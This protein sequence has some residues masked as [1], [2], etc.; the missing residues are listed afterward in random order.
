MM[1]AHITLADVLSHVRRQDARTAVGAPDGAADG[2]PEGTAGAQA[3]A[4]VERV[5]GRVVLQ[6]LNHE[7]EDT[8]VT[9]HQGG[10]S[11]SFVLPAASIT[12]ATW[13]V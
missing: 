2:A 5:S 12:T 4:F 13:T 3:V 9:V 1:L 10:S 11:A 6:L 7:L 8:H